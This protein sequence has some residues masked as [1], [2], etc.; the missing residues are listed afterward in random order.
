MNGKK[1]DIQW[2]SLFLFLLGIIS[3]ITFG[4]EQKMSLLL[5][6]LGFFCL[7]YASISVVPGDL[8]TQKLSFSTLMKVNAEASQLV[9]LLQVFGFLLLL[10]SLVF[11]LVLGI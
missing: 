4:V 2:P 8:F 6:A 3:I 7:A 11:G 10:T 9:V 5:Q 1:R